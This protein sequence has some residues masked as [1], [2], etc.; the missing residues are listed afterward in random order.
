MQRI[1]L[2]YEPRKPIDVVV[3]SLFTHHLVD[4]RRR[5]VSQVDGRERAHGLVYQRSFARAPIPY[6]LFRA[7]AKLAGLHPFV[8]HDGPVSIARAFVPEDW[9]E[10]CAAAGLRCRRR[11]DAGYTPGTLV[12]GRGSKR[13]DDAHDS[14]EHLVIGG[15]LAGSMVAMRL[16]AAGREVT[17]LEKERERIT[18]CAASS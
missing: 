5:A 3:S 14:V 9:R 13:S 11:D 12:R 7:F 15:G 4:E 8:Q 18:R 1:C 2:R 16:A 6:H 17:L 10:M